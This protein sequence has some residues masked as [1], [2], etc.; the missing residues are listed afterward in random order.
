M[1]V[2]TVDSAWYLG[3]WRSPLSAL[4][5]VLFVGAAVLARGNRNANQRRS[6]GLVAR[7]DGCPRWFEGVALALVVLSLG[8][9]V[10]RLLRSVD[11]GADFGFDR[12]SLVFMFGSLALLVLLQT[13]VGQAC[14]G[15]SSDGAERRG[16]GSERLTGDGT[17]WT[18]VHVLARAPRLVGGPGGHDRW[19]GLDSCRGAVTTGA[20]SIWKRQENEV[21]PVPRSWFGCSGR[22]RRRASSEG[23]G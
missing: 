22:A 10:R 16:R 23:F 1:A 21:V 5:G 3:E 19:S 8:V 20:A 4:V 15:T 7:L 18:P 6:R 12:S 13:R 14:G 9:S 17:G 2:W 11:E